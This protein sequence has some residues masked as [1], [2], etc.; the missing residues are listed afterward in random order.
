MRTSGV[1]I[2]LLILT[3]LSGCAPF[4]DS[5]YSD[6]LLRSERR[7]NQKSQGEIGN[8]EADGTVRIAVIADSHQNYRELDETIFAI[9]N[10]SDID[11][12]VNLG[13][14]TN[15]GYNLEFDQFIDSYVEIRRPAFTLQ[16]NHDSIGAGPAL[17]QKAFGGPNFWFETSSKR[18]I[19]FH[20]N[21]LEDLEHF[22]PQW[23][24]DA[25]DGSAKPVVIFSHAQLTD[26]ARYGA[27]TRAQL[28]AIQADAKVV[29][30]LNG[31]NHIYELTDNAGTAVLQVPRVENDWVLL[32]IQGTSL[33]I[34]QMKSGASTSVTLKQ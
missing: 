5:P 22:D 24:K 28:T 10:V 29:L 12:V 6:Q 7:L 8:P 31:H 25:V 21:D 4:L 3:S 1:G 20:T 30:T 16:G 33:T 34:R 14:F 19:F 18:W 26:D 9:N 11:F 15:S 2:L 17:F 23:L 13:D 32:E 27:A